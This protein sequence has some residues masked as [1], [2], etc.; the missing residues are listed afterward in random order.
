MY[1]FDTN[2][3]LSPDEVAFNNNVFRQ[4]ADPQARNSNGLA[5]LPV[6]TG[7]LRVPMITVHNLG[8]LF[9][10][11]L[12]E[13]EYARR[14]AEK[15]NSEF[16]VQRA[17]RGVGHCNITP[18]EF[19]TAFIDLVIWTEFGVRPAGD[20]YLDPANV[21]SP[22]FGCTFNDDGGHFLEEPCPTP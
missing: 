20:D 18:L 1:Q 19:S 15:G 12:H 7:D 22:D 13:I 16:L 9:V 14:V 4:M 8:D 10:P 11:I 2:P 6:T 17:I 5:Q 3:A 21:A